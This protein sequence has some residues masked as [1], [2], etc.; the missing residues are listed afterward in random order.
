MTSA[1]STPALVPAPA[2]KG[3][4]KE[5]IS[6]PKPAAPEPSTPS[7]AVAANFNADLVREYLNKDV[8]ED[9]DQFSQHVEPNEAGTPEALSPDSSQP[10]PTPILAV[11]PLK[12]DVALPVLQSPTDEGSPLTL[13]P[14]RGRAVGNKYKLPY[15]EEESRTVRTVV[16]K[17]DKDRLRSFGGFVVEVRP[18]ATALLT[19]SPQNAQ[20]KTLMKTPTNQR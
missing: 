4:T 20:T 8:L 15:D 9:P 2:T 18:S 5:P 7:P 10:E 17:K 19:N 1:S 14:P 11:S 13:E 16:G 3:S 6:K 12:D